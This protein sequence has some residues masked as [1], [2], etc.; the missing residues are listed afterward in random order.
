MSFIF[1]FLL[2]SLIAVAIIFIHRGLPGSSKDIGWKMS[3][4]WSNPRNLHVL[5]HA[6]GGIMRGHIVSSADKSITQADSSL[7]IKEL[8]VKPLWQ[9]SDGTY[10][11]PVSRQEHPVKLRLTGTRKICVKFLDNKTVEEW[12]LIDPL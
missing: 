9:W 3:G 12:R 2:F 6:N 5:L 8:A 7:V 4:V 10:V 1:L 11:E